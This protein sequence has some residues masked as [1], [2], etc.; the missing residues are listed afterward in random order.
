M[1]HCHDGYWCGD[2]YAIKAFQAAM[3]AKYADVA[4]LNLAWGV[5]LKS[6][7]D[8]LPP[9]EIS[10]GKFAPSPKVFPTGQDKRR[11][12]D[13]ITW[14]DQAIIGFAGQ[15][16]KA[17][18]KYFPAEKVRMK[19]GGNGGSVNAL[20]WGTYC[21]GYAKMAKG[22]GIVLQ[23]A[24]AQGAIFGDK[25]IATAYQFY[26]VKESTETGGELI[27]RAFA[28]RMF[29]DASC[30]VAQLFT[31]NY[32]RFAP[33][34]QKNIHLYTGK[35]GETEIAVYCPTTLH[36]LGVNLY[37]T[38]VASYPLRDICEYD[39]LDELLIADGALTT[40]R[41]KAL[42]LFQSSIVDQ[43]ILNEIDAF[44]LAGGK[45]IVPG[46]RPIMNVE[47]EP[48]AGAANIIHVAPLAKKTEWPREMAAQLAG[49]KGFEG[50]LDGIWTSRRGKEIFVFNSTKKPVEAK[51]DGRVVQIGPYSIYS[52]T[53]KH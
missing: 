44:R 12:L 35:P 23:P 28:Q 13:F 10:A 29:S 11:W 15:S 37:P 8:V 14:Y 1:G 33:E 49:L 52:T 38:I 39:V 31:Y 16:L 27:D 42:V 7:N 18:L 46:E 4:K 24:D 47:G 30:G 43:P 2:V 20:P 6:F 36:R 53:E 40:K 48:W 34:V 9:K 19:P 26:G 50:Q 45:V 32:A 3:Q 25:W 41:Y 21:P 17:V 51:I 5:T 22:S